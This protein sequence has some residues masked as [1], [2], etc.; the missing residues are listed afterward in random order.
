MR[1]PNGYGSVVKL[2]GKRRKPFMVRVRTTYT[3]NTDTGESKE[4]REIL[5]YYATRKEA[6]SALAEYNANPYD[7]A[8]QKHTFGELFDLWEAKQCKVK[9]IS[10][11]SPVLAAR[12]WTAPIWDRPIR[13]LK[14][15]ELQQVVDNCNRGAATKQIVKS[16]IGKIFK[17]AEEND[18]VSKNYATFIEVN[19]AQSIKGEPFLPEEINTIYEHRYE[20]KVDTLMV[21][22]LT[23]FRANELIKAT[24]HMDRGVYVGGLKTKAGKN[25]VVPIHPVVR[26][27]LERGYEPPANYQILRRNLVTCLRD[28]GLSFDA[29][30]N[31]HTA[32]DCRHTFSWLADRYDVDGMSKRLIL[33]HSAGI[34]I[35][36]MVYGH[37]TEEELIEEMNKIVLPVRY[38]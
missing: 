7:L 28:L 6:L 37:R 31:R 2:S 4:K 32:H 15:Y 11:T 21:L 30:G 20:P 35:T 18:M 22:I 17:L 14:T 13:E 24:L 29:K 26:D 9:D 16:H 38:Q 12:K 10:K 33:G 34:D 8:G 23:G 5:G 19:G 1:L 25:R 36:D 3:Y 27:L